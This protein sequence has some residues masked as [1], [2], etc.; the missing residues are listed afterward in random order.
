MRITGAIDA[1][2]NK[3]INTELNG[4]ALNAWLP[5]LYNTVG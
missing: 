3:S 2:H 5:R 1:K 4:G